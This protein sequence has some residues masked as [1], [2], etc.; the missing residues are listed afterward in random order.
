MKERLTGIIK[1][2]QQLVDGIFEMTLSVDTISNEATVGQFVNLYS[3]RKDLLLPRPI[4]ICEIDKENGQIKLVYAVVGKGTADFSQ[5]QEGDSIQMMGP[6]GNGFTI[7]EDT[8]EHVVVGGG[9]GVPPLLELV[10]RLKGDISV[11]L[12]FR[13]D[14]ILVKE[15]RMYTDKVYVATEDGSNG[16]KGNVIDLLHKHPPKATMI[17]SCG[18]KPMLKAVADW[19]KEKKIEA[20]LS[21]E[22]RM[23]CGI[24]ACL[25]CTCKSKKD[26]DWD[27]KRVCKDGPVFWRDEVMWDE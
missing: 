12:G 26:D 9:I 21:M 5:M 1:K 13:C 6:F 17:Y 18:P 23:A 7:S 22:E 10:K 25:V 4:S 27:Y 8:K 20:Q 14:P 3:I 24:G 2:N 15:F 16:V 19:S 11:Y